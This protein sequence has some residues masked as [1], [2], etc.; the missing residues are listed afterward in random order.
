VFLQA[1]NFVCAD[2]HQVLGQEEG[3][4]VESQAT[5]AHMDVS[6]VLGDGQTARQPGEFAE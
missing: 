5:Q 6:S 1:V 2:G 4:D 3:Q